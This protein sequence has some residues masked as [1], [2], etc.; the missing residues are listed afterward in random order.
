L[1]SIKVT[2]GSVTPKA[3]A[4]SR[5]GFLQWDSACPSSYWNSERVPA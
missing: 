5:P 2:P 3:L 4:I 1:D